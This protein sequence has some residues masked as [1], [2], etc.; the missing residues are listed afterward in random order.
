MSGD[1]LLPQFFICFFYI[2]CLVSHFFI[3][4]ST[5]RAHGVPGAG[6]VGEP[7]DRLRVSER[8]QVHLFHC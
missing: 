6:A 7:R 4:Q 5:V 8:Q 2:G 3:G 1:Y